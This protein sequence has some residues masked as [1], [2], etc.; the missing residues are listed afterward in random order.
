M[1]KTKEDKLAILVKHYSE[2]KDS[3]IVS[4]DFVEGIKLGIQFAQKPA[5]HIAKAWT[6]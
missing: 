4:E 5:A 2:L 3:G 6:K 1:P